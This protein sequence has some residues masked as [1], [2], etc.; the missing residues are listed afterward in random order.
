MS[1]VISIDEKYE[2]HEIIK[3][4]GFGIVYKGVDKLF[5]KPVAIKAVD[6]DLLGEARYIDMFQA[7]ALNIA[8]FSHHNIVH[9]Y[10]VKRGDEGQFYIIMEYIDGPDIGT[11]LRLC[12]HKNRPLPLHLGLYMIA[13]TCA[14]LD[15]A[16][17]RRDAKTN[18]PLNIVHQDISPSNIMLTRSGEIKII[19]FGMANLRKFKPQKKN[20]V[21]IQGKL[22]YLAPEQLDRE[23]TPDRRAD[24]FA[25]GLVLYEIVAG[26]RLIKS[27]NPQEV[28]ELLTAGTL[29]LTPALQNDLSP[30]LQEVLTHSLELDREKRYP[31]A[32]HM[33]M[34]L[35]HELILTAPAADFMSELSAFV[36]ELYTVE[37]AEQLAAG[38]QKT[39]VVSEEAAVEKSGDDTLQGMEDEIEL[40]NT[41]AGEPAQ[42]VTDAEDSVAPPVSDKSEDN[43]ADL[44]EISENLVE[45]ISEKLES[46]ETA[47]SENGHAEAGT[48]G[49]PAETE[50]SEPPFANGEVAGDAE[51]DEE[52]REDA[53]PG[54]A[55]RRNKRAGK[56]RN[57][58]KNKRVSFTTTSE[59]KKQEPVET[60]DDSG[61]TPEPDF[62]QVSPAPADKKMVS[63]EQARSFQP[64]DFFEDADDEVKTII[65]VVRLS[66]RNHQKGIV[67]GVIT[68]MVLFLTFTAVDTFARFTSYGSSIYDFFFPP[69]IIIESIPA[70]AEIF[71]DDEPLASTTPLRL[72][73]IPP[74]V[75]KLTLKLSR[76][77]PITRSITVPGNGELKVDGETGRHPSKP[78]V[79]VFK[80]RLNFSSNPPGA[81]ITINDITLAE[82][83][84]TTVFWDV[85][86]EPVQ[87]SMSRAG[88][89]SLT[90]LS[91]DMMEGSE[92][93]EDRRF[94]KFERIDETRDDFAIE[95]IFRKTVTIQSVPNRAEVLLNGTPVG[96]TGISGDLALTV[97][98][99]QITLQK[100][101]Y[102]SRTFTLDVNENTPDNIRAILL[103]RVSIAS[104]DASQITSDDL[105]A[106]ITR[107]EYSR[108]SISID[109]TTPATLQLQ[110]YACKITLSKEG[111]Q[112]T[113]V[114][115]GALQKEVIAS[116]QPIPAK[117]S[118]LIVDDRKDSG[119]P[120]AQIIYKRR[121][122]LSKESALG[123]TD[124]TGTLIGEIPPGTFQFTVIK[125]GYNAATKT[126]RVYLDRQNR[127][128]FRLTAKR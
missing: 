120:A 31:T 65:D 25:L 93:I 64:P 24:I 33:Y 96:L 37:E 38:M 53:A 123:A 55:V 112:D 51:K 122:T 1:T 19:D 61:A 83:T 128:T 35:M 71:L 59:D 47:S 66:A 9:V 104:R 126:M 70:G 10:D 79:F 54:F 102:I 67:T 107:V 72:E 42:A 36:N 12:K 28:V 119:I 27:S 98:K 3:K 57:R 77:E 13:E 43:G 2:I 127:I 106:R 100:R 16:H 118:I 125:P 73:E 46:D 20:E 91:L 94:W 124:S 85:Q 75:H 84:P 17:N 86:E 89:P 34:D 105:K 109:K 99:H 78:Y 74:G 81:T 22:N 44:G 97:G 56:K 11:L 62:A 95:G 114:T 69:A 23:I 15:Y 116:L 68:L 103:R 58:K 18:K 14:G 80:S 60:D 117:L 32:N 111:Y 21:V 87:I 7:E 52:L 49:A 76:F 82:K 41:E 6:P 121:G 39:A 30:K 48:D 113:V 110:P 63:E 4:G 90:G 45:E 101:G 92:F 26:E 108:R 5:D 29:D 40:L 50:T 115:V 8:R 88:F